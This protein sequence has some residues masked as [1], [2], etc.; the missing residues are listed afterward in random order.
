MTQPPFPPSGGGV[1]RGR[2]VLWILIA[3]A[4]IAGVAL[5]FTFGAGT[6]TLHAPAP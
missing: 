3:L 5:Y 6:A 1:P 2:L 4:I